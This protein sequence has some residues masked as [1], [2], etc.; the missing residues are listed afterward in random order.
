[1]DEMNPK[2]T[3]FLAQDRIAGLHSEAVGHHVL[4]RAAATSVSTTPV[5]PRAART[6]ASSF[7]WRLIRRA[8]A[9]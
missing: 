5:A 9:V 8:I 3:E 4:K 1:M 2:M 7:V 6:P